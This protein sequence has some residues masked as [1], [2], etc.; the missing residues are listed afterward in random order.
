[1]VGM[2]ILVTLN[3]NYLWP[4]KV[5]LKSMFYNNPDERFVIYLI[6]SS[7]NDAELDELDRFISLH[8]NGF[9]SIRIGDDMFQDAPT[10]LHYTKEMY[11]RLLACRFLPQQLDRVL[12]LDPDILVLNPIRDFY[13]L[14]MDNY[15]FA[16]SSHTFASVPE[17][18][19]LRLAPYKIEDYYNSG[20]LL[21]NLAL[22]RQVIREQDI[23]EFVS[24]YRMK[25]ML[26]DQDIMNALYAGYIRGLDEKIYN[27]DAR[28]YAYYKLTSNGECDMD[29]IINRTLFLHFCGKKK[30]WNKGYSGKFH[31]LYKHYEKMT[32]ESEARVLV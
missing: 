6:H 11:Y 10:L 29:F 24:R 21:M 15:M 22:H 26:P 32:K 25:L 19:K 27:Y 28:R 18:N 30:P 16:A 14:D 13:H 8:G 9:E 7:I 3:S 31:V 20:V 2:N 17:L 23:F 5:M 4:L 1:M 12:Y